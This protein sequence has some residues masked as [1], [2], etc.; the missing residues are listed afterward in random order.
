MDAFSGRYAPVVTPFTDDGSTL[1][2]IRLARQVRHLVAAGIDGLVLNGDAGEFTNLSSG[3]RK[4]VLEIV[5]REAQ[6]RVPVLVNVTRLGTLPTMDLAQHAARHGAR[7]AILTPPYYGRYTANELEGHF[8]A[9]AH[10]GGLATIVVDPQGLL[11]PEMRE[12]LATSGHMVFA[13]SLA[14]TEWEPAGFD[15]HRSDAFQLSDL[16]VS[17]LFTLCG[18]EL[19]AGEADMTKL[20]PVNALYATPTVLKAGLALLGVDVGSPRPPL[21]ALPTEPERRVAA[22]LGQST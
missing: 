6:G 14:G 12:R 13:D 22:A 18:G 10:H 1:S 17:P 9:V 15:P 16:T 8:R 21:L 19:R 7:A 5:L 11:G 3:E 2:E 4:A 20:A